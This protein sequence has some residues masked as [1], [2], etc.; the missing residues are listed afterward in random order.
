MTDVSAYT[1]RA[2]AFQKLLRVGSLE[3]IGANMPFLV[4]SLVW[5]EYRRLIRLNRQLSS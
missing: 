2:D 1:G 3:C 5:T 4:A